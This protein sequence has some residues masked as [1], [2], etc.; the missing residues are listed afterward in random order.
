LVFFTYL[1]G[2]VL[3]VFGKQSRV[4]LIAA[5]GALLNIILNV[6][7]IPRFSLIGTATATVATEFVV[8]ILLGLSLRSFS[9]FERRT[10]PIAQA[11]LGTLCMGIFLW[12]FGSR[13]PLIFSVAWAVAIYGMALALTGALKNPSAAI[14]RPD[15]P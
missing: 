15:V 10:F 12:Q 7:L 9:V 1:Y 13:L 11:A 3:A 8:L 5:I 4:T 2:Q 6:L 14:V